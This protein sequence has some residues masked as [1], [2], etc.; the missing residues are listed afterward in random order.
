MPKCPH[1]KVTISATQYASGTC[2]VCSSQ[3][4]QEPSPQDSWGSGVFVV[5]SALLDGPVKLPDQPGEESDGRAT[6]GSDS[7]SLSNSQPSAGSS[8][9]SAAD[10]GARSDSD[11]DA[12]SESIGSSLDLTPVKG[13]PFDAPQVPDLSVAS[14]A[15]QTLA[16][17]VF[18]SSRAPDED[19]SA[20]GQT[21]VSDDFSSIDGISE[22]T[23]TREII[24]PTDSVDIKKPVRLPEDS[25][26]GDS[27]A[28]DSSM[29]GTIMSDEFVAPDA[30]LTSLETPP[31]SADDDGGKT[32]TSDEFAAVSES[33]SVSDSGE[34]G[35]NR[36]VQMDSFEEDGGGKTV[37]GAGFDL[38]EDAGGKTMVSAEWE[39]EAGADKTF[40]SDDI[41][42]EVAR[43]MKTMWSGAFEAGAQPGATIKA[44]AAE[45]ASPRTSLVIKS[46]ALH[47]ANLG[48]KE[49]GSSIEDAE[50]ELIKVLGEGGMGIVYTARQTSIDRTVAV[51]MLKPNTSADE[52]QRQK[53]L[54][55]AVVTGD[56]DHPNIVP[57][58]DVGRNEK[59]ALFY[60]MKKVQGKP[61]LD[62]MK[63]KSLHEN[64]EILMR[65]AD[66]VAFAHAR[67]IVHRDLKPENTMLGEFG[68]VLVMDW[69]LAYSLP[70]FRKSGSITPNSGMGG[71]PSYMAPEMATGPLEKIGP[72]SDIYLLG[73]ILFEIVTG[74]PPHAG[75]NAMQCLMAAAK[76]DIRQTD[77]TGELIDIARKAMATKS[78]DR[79][80]TV[81]DLQTAVREYQ[82]HTESIVL[83]ARA[84]EDLQEAE[85]SEDY[86]AYSRALFAF[87]EALN[88]WKGNTR[89]ATG[90]AT[91][92]LS[93]ARCAMRKGDY[94]LGVS[95]LDPENKEHAEVL[96]LI[97]VAQRERDARQHKLKLAKQV[98]VGLVALVFVVVSVAFF[99]VSAARDRAEASRI[100]AVEAKDEADRRREE[101]ELARKQEEIAKRNAVTSEKEAVAA[102]TRAEIAR[103]QAE[104]AK[105]AEEYEAYIARIGLAAA[106]I[107]ENAFGSALELLNGCKPELRNWEWGRLMHLCSQSTRTFDAQAPVDALAISPDG[108][109]FMT[110]SWN[111]QARI[112]DVATG[113]LL[114]TL[115][116]NGL[117]IHAVTFSRDGKLAATGGNDK[118]GY[119]RV[120]NAETGEPVQSLQGH[121]DA[122]LSVA[123]SRDGKRLLTS[124]YDNTA[125][126]WDIASGKQLQL[127][128]GHNWWVWDAS[129]SPDEKQVVTA[130]QDGTAII[131][132]VGSPDKGLPFIGH[133]GP[134]YSAVFSPDGTHVASGGYDKR[135]LFWKTTDVHPY[136]YAK[137][138]AG[139]TG[140]PPKFQAFDGHT[141]GVRSVVFSHDGAL[142]G[143]GGHDNTVKV[144]DLET[145]KS[146]KTFRGHDSWVRACAFSPDGRWVISGSH[147]H[148]AKLWSIAEYEEIRVLQGRVLHAH[149]DAVL[150]ASFS[151][152]G[153]S[154]VTASRDRTAKTWDFQSGAEQHVFE[155]GHSF[156]A[157]SAVFFPDGKRLLTAAVDNTVRGWD[158][159]TGTQNLRMEHTGRSAALSL[160]HNGQYILTG[161]DDQTAQLWNAETGERIRKFEGH[162]AEITAVA[163]SPD[164]RL[165]CAGDSKGRCSLFD[166][167]TGERK[168]RLDH[169]SRRISSVVFRPDGKHVLT[170]SGDNTVGQWDV[171]TGQELSAG[172]LKHPD[173]V[174]SMT[175]TPDGLRVLTGCDDGKVRLWDIDKATVVGTLDS[176]P[177]VV[178]S[179]AISHDGRRALTANSEARV[180]RVWDL[181][182]LREILAPDP[183]S[184]DRLG[185]FLDLK[186]RGGLLWS[187]AFSPD[188]TQILSVGG[189][190]ARLWDMRNG[191]ERMS[192]SP[193]GA[194]ASANFSP[195]GRRIV[196]GSWDNSAKIWNV[197]T[198]HSELKLEGG[199]TGY[200]NS[201]VFSPDGKTVL[202][203]SDDGTA[204]LWDS[205]TGTVLKTYAGHTGRVRS[206]IF[207]SDGKHVVTASNDKTARLWD[208]ETAE[209]L[210]TFKGHVWAVLCASLVEDGTRLVTGSDDNTARVWDVSTGLTLLTLEGH[211]ASLTSVAFSPDGMRLLTGSQ[212]NTA[213]LWDAKTGKEI[214]T[215]K[216]HSQEVTSVNFSRNGRHALTGSRDGTAIVWLAVDW[217]EQKGQLASS[218]EQPAA[219]P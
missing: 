13:L 137:L 67:G 205:T 172:V 46:K 209:L 5:D 109:Q 151:P 15:G 214:L 94:D 146:I 96:A 108:K 47:T 12:G 87:Q 84:E 165:V 61:W 100:A 97:R 80:Q 131:W 212:D 217:H 51:K 156:L 154:I 78:D 163:F 42:P 81:Q 143:S 182:N 185:P 43:T 216:G 74:K 135:V 106:K 130:S 166:V 2:P 64:L 20:G 33:G 29:E 88:L 158:V 55:E 36:T 184:N 4:D 177:D 14:S 38:G 57:I 6:G 194:V 176:G 45:P 207:S 41:T 99:F 32:I 132:T 77:K 66:A 48:T 95:L 153:S 118:T 181:E 24:P 193:H 155:E 50:Y 195:D 204:K 82:S 22:E 211:T 134:V 10:S 173:S 152:D 59:G 138:V 124:S 75:K 136:D 186:R 16:S 198:G 92:R 69:G 71:T 49:K 162:R 65:V 200:V 83:S 28:G 149:P 93:Y 70:K 98:A 128:R 68:E 110:G 60:S 123:F 103:E 101:A 199:H 159:A 147:D 188:D 145:G 127:F 73:A 213:K 31:V 79:Y 183:S 179:L 192:F 161:G 117:Y 218:E 178:H 203:G 120:W 206:A 8:I 180:V 148:L 52:S 112:W 189:S 170:A 91:A 53:F 7:V 167:Q 144:W 25:D 104:I 157:S 39:D 105:R 85:K 72:C 190:E 9:N 3:I 197:E 11:A 174:L 21:F 114:H 219:R 125:R 141:A 40:V 160:S 18:G 62:I 27:G 90:L 111:S 119:A 86:Q 164:D 17:D 44:E 26:A 1:C 208:M 23:G 129:F 201:A 187:A 121:G 175:I 196:T 215:L 37:A 30:G 139:D 113:K 140:E 102:R 63:E 56:L 191:T 107:D 19:D 115:P 89:A 142:L 169:H 116:H 171:E 122:V 54:A 210:A 126:L 133:R 202:T 34:D 58:Y 150:S 76:N 35:G 168:L